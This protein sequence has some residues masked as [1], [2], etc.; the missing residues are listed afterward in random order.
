MKL[1]LAPNLCSLRGSE[2]SDVKKNQAKFCTF[3]GE[4]RTRSLGQC[5][6]LYLRPNLRN[7]IDPVLCAA[8][9]S[10]VLIK[11]EEKRKLG[12]VKLKTG[13]KRQMASA[14]HTKAAC[15]TRSY[16]MF[17]SETA[18]ESMAS[19]T[20]PAQQQLGVKRVRPRVYGH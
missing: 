12:D 6:K 16:A 9:E 2:L 13:R 11:R 3:L 5:M 15:C 1:F 19:S 18:I 10:R 4:G 7:T 20:V 8:A 14:V 17:S